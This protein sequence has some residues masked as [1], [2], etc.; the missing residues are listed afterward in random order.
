[1]FSRTPPEILRRNFWCNKNFHRKFHR[2]YI[3]NFSVL[4]WLSNLWVTIVVLQLFTKLMNALVG[5]NTNLG[6]KL[7][8]NDATITLK[9]T[10]QLL[11]KIISSSFIV[12]LNP[13][14]TIK[15]VSYQ[16]FW[17]IRF[18]FHL[19][20]AWKIL[21]PIHDAWI[22]CNCNQEPILPS[23]SIQKSSF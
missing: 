12:M 4:T 15:I 21:F 13:Y 6:K 20:L 7:P 3:E 23:I 11:T 14:L 17:C 18:P 10:T 8:K 16:D 2:M 22:G 1:M 9:M 19:L 5:S